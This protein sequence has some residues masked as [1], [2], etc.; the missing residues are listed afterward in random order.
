MEIIRVSGQFWWKENSEMKHSGKFEVKKKE[1]HLWN[2]I[3]IM[4][5]S[6]GLISPLIR[7]SC[8]ES[9]YNIL[10]CNWS[11]VMLITFVYL[12]LAVSC[13]DVTSTELF[14]KFYCSCT[15]HLHFL[16]LC[17]FGKHFPVFLWLVLW[18]SVY[19]CKNSLTT[20]EI[21]F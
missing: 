14:P 18:N 20:E 2:F 12:G 11:Y 16:I 5:I 19:F 10:F 15:S 3:Y 9:Y 8:V 17:S 13:R 1:K 7:I 4:N 6:R 21:R